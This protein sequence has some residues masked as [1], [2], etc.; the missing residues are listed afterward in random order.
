MVEEPLTKIPAVEE[1][2]VMALVKRRCQAPGEPEEP[3]AQAEPVPVI[4]PLVSA[5]RHWVEPEIPVTA[6]L[7]E[8]AAVAVKLVTTRVV[9]S[10][11]VVA[12]SRLSKAVVKPE[13]WRVV[14]TVKVSMTEEVA[15]KTAAL[16]SE[17]T[18][19]PVPVSPVLSKKESST[20]I[21]KVPAPVVQVT[22]S[23]QFK[24]A[25]T[26]SA[27]VEPIS[28]CPFVPTASGVTAPVPEP[29]KTP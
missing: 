9:R 20:S 4:V 19:K 23:A 1:V 11:V 12:L 25:K 13:P 18:N 15:F 17:S 3:V 7:V 21:S 24:A 2:G 28:N 16:R 27:P 22:L 8:V 6:R 10:K 29:T 5:W 14:P 26:G